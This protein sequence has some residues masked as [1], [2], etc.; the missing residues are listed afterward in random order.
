M[1][2]AIDIIWSG[3]LVFAGKLLGKHVEDLVDEFGGKIMVV[4]ATL[5]LVGVIFILPRLFKKLES[6]KSTQKS[7]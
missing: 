1:K 5:G 4:G 6:K 7:V 3:G 2:L